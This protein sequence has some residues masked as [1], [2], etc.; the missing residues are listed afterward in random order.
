MLEGGFSGATNLVTQQ[1]T[2]QNYIYG[3]AESDIIQGTSSLENIYGYG[4]DDVLDGGAGNDT[5]D[6]GYGNDVYRFGRGSGNDIITN[7]DWAAGKRDAIVMGEGIST[8]DVAVAREGDSLVLSVKGTS[9]SIRVNSYFYADA[10]YG[11]QVEEVRFADGAT[12]DIAAIKSL[13]QLATDG[14]DTL[15]G[16]AS[17]DSLSG[18]LGEDNL[19]GMGGDDSLRGGIGADTL[20]GN[21]G[22]DTLD[23]GDQNDRLYGGTGND[24]LLGGVGTDSLS[25]E[26]GDDLLD[27]GAGNDTLD[28]GFGNDVYI[29]G[30]GSGNDLI[31]NYDWTADKRD[32][33]VMG[34]GISTGDVSVARD[35]DSLVLSIKG[36]SDSV[37]VNSYFYA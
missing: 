14:N 19:S 2:T 26:N 3:T 18:G 5:L 33:I 35:G 28:G 4:G 13:V 23:G 20:Y 36:T 25:G 34:E 1:P 31:V 7:N 30:R 16:Y 22:D 32:A 6:G 10:T 8:E 21:E 27:G 17:A 24:L 15:I 12:W 29:F 37:R 11:Y 9:D